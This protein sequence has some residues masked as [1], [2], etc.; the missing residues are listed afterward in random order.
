MRPPPTAIEKGWDLGTQ[1]FGFACCAALGPARSAN[2]ERT[3]T[4]C[5]DRIAAVRSTR[6]TCRNSTPATRRSPESE[7]S[8]HKKHEQRGSR[9]QRMPNAQRPD[10]ACGPGI[11][12]S[13]SVD[14]VF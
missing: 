8:N 10:D 2:S 7:Q 5:C 13:A 14:N 4:E 6:P 12:L 3:A 1:Y 11:Y 9:I